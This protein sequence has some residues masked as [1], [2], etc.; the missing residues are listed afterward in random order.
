MQHYVPHLDCNTEKPGGMRT[1][2]MLLGITRS[3]V[4]AP[5]WAGWGRGVARCVYDCQGARGGLSCVHAA[6]MARPPPP[7]TPPPQGARHWASPA[8]LTGFGRHGRVQSVPRKVP[9]QGCV[10]SPSLRLAEACPV[11]CASSQYEELRH[12]RR[13]AAVIDLLCCR[14]QGLLPLSCA[15]KL[16]A[17]MPGALCELGRPGGALRFWL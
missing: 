5:V 13:H 6:R 15:Q 7:L 3:Y 4:G 16:I 11:P 14:P 9:L 1:V 12:C 17:T 10:P 2:G 8:C